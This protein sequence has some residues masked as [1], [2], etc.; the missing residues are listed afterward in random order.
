MKNITKEEYNKIIESSK[1]KEFLLN[2]QIS[3]VSKEPKVD[4]V[5]KDG[6]LQSGIMQSGI[7]PKINSQGQPMLQTMIHSKMHKINVINKPKENAG[8]KNI[9]HILS[10]LMI[11]Y[12]SELMIRGH[13]ELMTDINNPN[14]SELKKSQKSQSQNSQKSQSQKSQSQIAQN[15]HSQIGQ[16]SQNAQSQIAQIAQRQNSQ[17]AQRPDNPHISIVKIQCMMYIINII[18]DELIKMG[19]ECSIIDKTEINHYISLNNSMHYFLFLLVPL[20]DENVINYKRYIL[21]QLEQNVNE[22]SIH[23]KHLHETNQLQQIYDNATLL[24]DYSEIN[25]NVTKQYYS[26]EFK[27]MNVPAINKPINHK[28]N[29]NGDHDGDYHEFDYEYNKY[30]YDIIFI[31]CVNKRRENILNQLQEKYKVLIVKNV[32]GEELK[33]LCDKSNICLNIH[34]YENA[35][36]E[37]VR[38]NEMMDYGIKIISERPCDDI[39]NYQSIH[40]IE[41]IDNLLNLDELITTIEKIKDI[42]LDYDTYDY[43]LN[44]LNSLFKE[45]IKILKPFHY[46]KNSFD[47][48]DTIIARQCKDPRDIFDIVE[49]NFPYK[50]FKN[51]RIESERIAFEKYNIHMNMDDIYD[52]FK[53]LTN[54]NDHNIEKIKEYEINK[55]IEYSIPIVSN[56]NKINPGDIYVSDMYLK[57]EH[58]YKLLSLHN[59]N[60]DNKLYVTSGGKS[61]GAIYEQLLKKYS[62]QMHTGD[63]Y[64]SDIIMAQ[65]YK[66]NTCYTT[67]SSFTITETLLYNMGCIN[68]QKSIRKFRLA[69]PYQINSIEY[70]LYNQQITY[71]IPLLI[72][73]SI[74]I[75]NIIDSEKLNKVLFFTRD[76]CLL[77]IIF[78]KLYPDIEIMEY[79]SSRVVHTYPSIGYIN[80]I[81]EHYTN[82][83]IIIDLHGSFTSG[84]K[85]YM[86]IFNKYPRVHL[87][88]YD[89]FSQSYDGL[90]Y[91]LKFSHKYVPYIEVLNYDM[92]GTLYDIVNNIELRKNNENNENY[93]KVS[94]DTVISYL[95]HLNLKDVNIDKNINIVNLIKDIY[96]D[97]FTE[98]N[99]LHIHNPPNILF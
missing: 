42:N 39:S 22:L 91:T 61:T 59:I 82:D 89:N 87:F 21:Y 11:Q 34:Y 49:N 76:C 95:H 44:K 43:D 52:A 92:K 38:L 40:F 72:L 45:D 25:I 19:W 33:K 53:I 6:I 16:N 4:K 5:D 26:N 67:I 63:N 32:Y 85:L 35:I 28:S 23:Y 77:H 37:R 66:I 56:I 78:H 57:P 94:H 10:N 71:N 65:K 70:D 13:S 58:I 46:I 62:I 9:M 27:L 3:T 8:S 1:K 7:M 90:T 88:D 99:N 17:I 50:N 14:R 86:S 24:L 79:A 47:I 18:K 97:I 98:K 75:K 48:F 12:K 74:Q 29:R 64:H 31:G 41:T 51:I 68:F 54:E 30:D 15:S 55:E 60:I 2:K 20:I 81:K 80:Y 36:L 84:R 73:F 83:S 93:I 96:S 69:N